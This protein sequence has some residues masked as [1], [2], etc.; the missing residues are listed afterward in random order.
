MGKKWWQHKMSEL[1]FSPRIFFF[2]EKMSEFTNSDRIYLD[3]CIPLAA[4]NY[5]SPP[6]SWTCLIDKNLISKRKNATETQ[7]FG[8]KKKYYE[9]RLCC[10]AVGVFVNKRTSF[11]NI[12][13]CTLA[14]TRR[15]GHRQCCGTGPCQFQKPPHQP[16][17][18]F[19]IK[20]I[21]PKTFENVKFAFEI[22]W[23]HWVWNNILS[24]A[25]HEDGVVFR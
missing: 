20:I 16:G 2:A 10:V 15:R 1:F 18:M 11:E 8:I 19:K 12:G 25:W 6:H 14:T 7:Y 5:G 4:W 22:K 3:W 13:R 17:N 21:W 24:N 23:K 9:K